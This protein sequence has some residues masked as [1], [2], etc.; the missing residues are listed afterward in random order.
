M[1]A[2]GP[3]QGRQ[4]HHLRDGGGGAGGRGFRLE[5]RRTRRSAS[6]PACMIGSGIGGLPAIDEASITLQEKGPRRIVAVLHPVGADQ[7]RLR[8][9]LDPVRLQGPEPCGGHR[10]LDRRACDRRCG[11]ADPARRCRRDGGRRRRGRDLPARHRRLRRLPRA[12]DRLQRRR[13]TARLAPLGQGPRRLRHG[14]GR[15]RRGARG[16]RARQGARREDLCRGDRLRPVGR[17]LPHH[18]AVGGRRRRASARCRW[19]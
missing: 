6:A 2:Q 16:I 4:L 5:A 1:C 7:P 14:R 3:A 13:P 18:R 17:R 19:R 8:P 15:R 10:L 11:A 9:G 12:V